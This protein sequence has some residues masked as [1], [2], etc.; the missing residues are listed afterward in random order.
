MMKLLSRIFLLLSVAALMTGCKLAVIAVEGGSV[1]SSY[2]G[3]CRNGSICIHEVANTNF[4]ETF[5]AVPSTGWYFKKWNSGDH[6]FC[7]DST[8]V[9]CRLSLES[10]EGNAGVEALV[11]S[12]ETFYIMPVFK[13]FTNTVIVDGKKWYQPYLFTGLSWE[14]IRAVCPDGICNGALK[15]Q[16]MTGWTWA[17]IE[18][19]NALFNH[20]IGSEVI[21]PGPDLIFESAEAGFD[22]QRA[23]Y[24]DGWQPTVYDQEA[25]HQEAHGSHDPTRIIGGWMRD[26]SESGEGFFGYMG[27]N[28]VI[29]GYGGVLDFAWSNTDQR[30]VDSIDNLPFAG[31]SSLGGWFYLAP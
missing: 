26:Q 31:P 29:G 19:V 28:F 10:A 4:S 12:S 27:I 23:F 30:L 8:Y 18:D 9:S 14:A 25:L 5:R 24:S 16:D 1:E 13:R 6:F 22:W 15:G 7:A 2:N 3:L 11:A 21:G 17:S 20:Y